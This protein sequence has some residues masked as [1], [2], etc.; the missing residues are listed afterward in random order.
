M[1]KL[2]NVKTSVELDLR[3]TKAHEDIYRL[4]RVTQALKEQNSITVILI[5]EQSI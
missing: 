5:I 1:P 4:T 3:A 2:Q